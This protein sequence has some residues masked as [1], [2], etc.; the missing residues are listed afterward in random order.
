[1]SR[2]RVQLY[3][4]PNQHLYD[5]LPQRLWHAFWIGSWQLRLTLLS[6]G[7]GSGLLISHYLVRCI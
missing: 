5:P 4:I 3:G 2:Y 6:I 7:A 1:M